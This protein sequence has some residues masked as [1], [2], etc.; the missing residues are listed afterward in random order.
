MAVLGL[1]PIMNFAVVLYCVVHYET[2]VKN[3]MGNTLMEEG[4]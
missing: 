3:A 1:I 2:I 4:A